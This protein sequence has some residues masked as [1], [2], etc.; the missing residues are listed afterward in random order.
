MKIA[1]IHA[2]IKIGT[3]IDAINL[4]ERLSLLSKVYVL[5]IFINERRAYDISDFII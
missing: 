3:S 5:L 2:P 1:S 4:Y